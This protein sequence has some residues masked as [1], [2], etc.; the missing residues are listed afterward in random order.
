MT[1]IEPQ[2]QTLRI[3]KTE[4]IA[5][6]PEV[7]WEAL[8]HQMGP[9]G[10]FEPGQSM[11]MKLEPHVGGRWWRDLANNTGHLWG[12]VQVIKP[13]KLLEIAGPMFMSYAA[14]SHVQYKI[15]PDGATTRLE[16]TH[17]A[18]GLIPPDHAAG[19]DGGWGH[20]LKAIREHAE[21]STR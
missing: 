7:V 18:M 4:T 15:V 9:G 10:E 3:S 12:H 11:S 20:Q 17:T 1:T 8:M 5:A 19:V 16:L 13:G 2:V 6:S 21:R 14:V